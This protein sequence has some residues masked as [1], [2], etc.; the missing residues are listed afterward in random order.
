M[1][2]AT[3]RFQRAAMLC[4]LAKRLREVG[5]WSGETHLQKAVFLLEEGRDVPLGLGFVLYKYG[6]FSVDVREELDELQARGFVRLEPQEYPYGARVAVAERGEQLLAQYSAFLD[7]FGKE[8]DEVVEY[9][10]SRGVSALER[11]TTAVYLVKEDPEGDDEALAEELR[12]VKPHVSGPA[13]ADAI[14]RARGF[15]DQRQ[16]VG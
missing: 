10:G 7:E 4:R 8:T 2:E 13:A 3:D 9:L 12:R 14:K 1:R 15:L 5:S 11:L 16:S 6:P